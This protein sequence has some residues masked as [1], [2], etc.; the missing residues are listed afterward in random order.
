VKEHNKV[1]IMT[2]DLKTVNMDLFHHNS[3]GTYVTNKNGMRALYAKYYET[4]SGIEI[5]RC[6][7]DFAIKVGRNVNKMALK[8]LDPEIRIAIE[9]D[10]DKNPQLKPEPWT[11]LLKFRNLTNIEVDEKI[12]DGEI[13]RLDDKFKLCKEATF[14][15]LR[16][17]LEL[18]FYEENTELFKLFKFNQKSW[19]P[20]MQTGAVRTLTR[21]LHN[22]FRG[23]EFDY[24]FEVMVKDKSWV[25]L[26]GGVT[27][28]KAHILPGDVIEIHKKNEK[29]HMYERVVCESPRSV[30][31]LYL[32]FF[33]DYQLKT[34]DSPNVV[35]RR[36]KLFDANLLWKIIC[37]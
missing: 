16:G 1:L 5:Y 36:E 11:K 2:E 8:Y 18:L 33:A 20:T 6:G 35:L 12:S 4:R 30:V 7:D 23:S 15:I 14:G 29:Q 13:D 28:G 26:R 34:I 27:V 21:Y 10:Y 25:Q 9:S 24:H 22:L 32:K 17:H 19:Y 3:P 37:C 31:L